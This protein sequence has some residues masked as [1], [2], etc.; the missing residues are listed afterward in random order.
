MALPNNPPPSRLVVGFI[1]S[2]DKIYDEVKLKLE[3]IFGK[4]KSFSP[5]FIFDHTNYYNK[6]LGKDLK[7]Q[8]CT[9]EKLITR[10][11]LARIKLIT[12]DIEKTFYFKDSSNRQINIDPGVISLENFVLASCKGFAHRIYLN[13]GVYADLTLIYKGT[14]FQLL[15]WTYPDYKSSEILNYLN[16]ER[17]ELKQEL[18]ALG[19]LKQA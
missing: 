11:E 16:T 14:S 17:R 9:F 7:R 1:F 3:S 12:N 8:I 2:D 6:E 18:T 5:L 13:D 15:E 19:F 10:S 4:I